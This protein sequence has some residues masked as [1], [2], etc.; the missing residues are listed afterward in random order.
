MVAQIE[1]VSRIGNSE[2]QRVRL[3]GLRLREKINLAT[4]RGVYLNAFL[5]VYSPLAGRT[6]TANDSRGTEEGARRSGSPLLTVHSYT[7]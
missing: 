5:R 6:M 1:G 2:V 7:S 3:N 4:L